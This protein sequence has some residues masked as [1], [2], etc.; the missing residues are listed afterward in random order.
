M[1]ILTFIIFVSLTNILL[2]QQRKY[3][4]LFFANKKYLLEIER[5]YKTNPYGFPFA[6]AERNQRFIYSKILLFY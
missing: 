3:D 1:K 6:I 4:T 2:G 5:P